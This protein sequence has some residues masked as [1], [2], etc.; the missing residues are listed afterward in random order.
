MI[1]RESKIKSL[2]KE[3]QSLVKG[4]ISEYI[5][6]NSVGRS[7]KKIVLEYDVKEKE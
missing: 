1:T 2:I 7:S 5:T 4:N 6:S 3:L